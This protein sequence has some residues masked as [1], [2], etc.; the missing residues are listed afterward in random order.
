ML[1]AS[2]VSGCLTTFALFSPLF[3]EVKAWQN[4]FLFVQTLPSAADSVAGVSSHTAIGAY[5]RLLARCVQV[6]RVGGGP[7][8]PS[9]ALPLG[10]SAAA[11]PLRL[12]RLPINH[13]LV[14]SLLAVSHAAAPEQILSSNVAGF[15]LV[16]EVDMVSNYVLAVAL[17]FP[18]FITFFDVK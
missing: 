16:T 8:A 14:N 6:Y 2:P 13:E 9:S 3:C 4:A 5:G 11:D 1:R 18:C 17:I 15:I 7:R 12:S 10:A